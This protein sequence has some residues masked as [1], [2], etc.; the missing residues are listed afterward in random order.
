MTKEITKAYILQQIEDRFGL[1]ELIPEKFSFSEMVQPVYNIDSHLTSWSNLMKEISITSAAGFQ[2]FAVPDA[3]R[4]FLGN[5]N[6]VFMGAGAIK[7]TGAYI[8]RRESGFVTPVYLDMTLNQTV[9][10]AVNLPAP[11]MLEPGDRIY[12][13]CDDYTSTQNLRLYVMVRRETLR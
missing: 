8:T 10:Y 2:F 1:R 6:V 5:Y 9:S 11:I 4:W 12:I 3:E 13:L 7:V